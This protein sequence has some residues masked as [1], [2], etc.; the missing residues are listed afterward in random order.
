LG[1]PLDISNINYDN[2]KKGN[3]LLI[4]GANMGG[5]STL[6][7]SIGVSTWLAQIGSYVPAEHFVYCP[8]KSIYTRIL[9]EDNIEKGI[10]A[11]QSEMLELTPI[12]KKS[13]HNSL[14]LADELAHS[15]TP[16]DATAIVASSLIQISAQKA[17]GI[18]TSHFHSILKIPEVIGIEGL[19]IY[20][21]EMKIGKK[22]IEYTHELIE[23]PGDEHY[24]IEVASF[25]GIDGN[26]I[27]NAYKFRRRLIDE[28]EEFLT[29]KTSHWN[30]NLYK[31]RSC[32]QCGG[33]VEEIHHKRQR[34]DA[35]NGFVDHVKIHSIPNLEKL[36]KKCHDARHS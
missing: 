32:E 24:G 33:K 34:K 25:C 5:K 23:G 35:V 18:F 15:T 14:I 8:V 10:S 22:N 16:D 20:N 31:G 28:S 3:I 13:D 30:S 11:F 4:M 27:A 6:L 2:V 26:V 29:F 17:L 1:E 7:R 12:L 36:C 9:T 21:F 19:S